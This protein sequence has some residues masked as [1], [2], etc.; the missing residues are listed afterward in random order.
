[1]IFSPDFPAP[2][3]G[4]GF[5]VKPDTWRRAATTSNPVFGRRFGS[6]NGIELARPAPLR[7]N[8]R[9][10]LSMVNTPLFA[11]VIGQEHGENG[12]AN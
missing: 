10:F 9:P 4:D 5:A 12:P 3:E 11:S 1:M 2:D 7:L 8:Q 6:Q